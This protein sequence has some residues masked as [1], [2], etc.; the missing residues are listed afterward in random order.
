MFFNKYKG[1]YNLQ[2]VFLK[3]LHTSQMFL[4]EIIPTN[5]SL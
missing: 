5:L 3:S 2:D 1:P 4:N